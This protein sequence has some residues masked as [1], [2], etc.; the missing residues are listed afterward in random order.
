MIPQ[1]AEIDSLSATD[2]GSQ[3]VLA[4]GGAQAPVQPSVDVA[5][6]LRKAAEAV[7]RIILEMEPADHRALLN[8][9]RLARQ[10]GDA[11]SALGYF[12]A[13][14]AAKPRRI[15]PKLEMARELRTLSRLDEA[16][17][18]YLDLLK[19][20]PT[21]VRAL[22]GLGSIARAR[23]KPRAA[24]SYYRAALA[25]K[26]SRTNLKLEVAAELRKLSRF[27]EA[28][29]LYRHILT[30]QP[31]HARARERLAR[32]P[33]PER[34]GLAVMERSWLERETF[35]RAAEWGRNLESLGG[36]PYRMNLLDL[37]L[38]F[39]CGASE[40][41]K[42]D[43]I[44]LRLRKATKILPLVS[45]WEEYEHVLKREVAALQLG[46]RLGYVPS[47]RKEGW[48][49]GLTVVRS[50]QEFV[51]HRETV[52]EMLGSSLQGARRNIR[53][54]LKAGAHLEPID[55]NNMAR[56]LACNARWYAGVKAKG[57]PA[58]QRARTI[59]TLE[60]LPLLEPL[61]VRH[62]AVML[63]GDVIGYGIGS[64]L[65]ASWIA[66]VYG[67][68]DNEYDVAPLIAQARSKLYPDR[69]WINAGDAGGR[70]SLAAFKRRFTANAEDKQLMMGWIQA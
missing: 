63:D 10:R 11:P 40:E 4:D 13:A 62:V 61:G 43:C 2:A 32:L 19:R 64:H 26:P 54:L 15:E 33:K 16:E 21:L 67:R 18:L 5:A 53:K 34:S 30:D 51:W 69:V 24:L 3:S 44:L 57:R 47:E 17:T 68:G 6:A 25:A 58:L 9:G 39:A 14:L 37:A 28:E 35:T 59:W 60:N 55:P 52:S 66:Y 42:R 22:V 48:R 45:D 1:P 36:P 49:N 56:V 65:A 70:Q 8:L 29:Q 31:D 46:S 12:E 23:G 50:Q 20:H 7:H 38:D 41:I 27:R